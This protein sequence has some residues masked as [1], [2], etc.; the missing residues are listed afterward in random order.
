LDEGI[1]INGFLTDPV[2]AEKYRKFEE[3]R[4]FKFEAVPL[5]D[6]KICGK[7]HKKKCECGNSGGGRPPAKPKTPGMG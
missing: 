5:A 7:C 4:E 2:I 1:H 6:T 3:R